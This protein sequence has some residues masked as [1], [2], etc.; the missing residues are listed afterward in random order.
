[1]KRKKEIYSMEYKG[2]KIYTT[3]NAVDIFS[4]II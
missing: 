3:S 4:V 2:R 1:M